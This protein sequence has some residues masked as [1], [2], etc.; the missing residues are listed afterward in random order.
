M[1]QPMDFSMIPKL[2]GSSTSDSYSKH[3]MPTF[4]KS[5]A[6]AEGHLGRKWSCES[7]RGIFYETVTLLS[8]IA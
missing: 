4:Q 7:A 5:V 2:S 1:T 6:K 8:S 3:Y